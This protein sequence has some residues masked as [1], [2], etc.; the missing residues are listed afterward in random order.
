MKDSSPRHA[1]DL[2]DRFLL[3]GGFRLSR[4]SFACG[5]NSRNRP[6]PPVQIK[7]RPTL[8]RFGRAAASG[9]NIIPGAII[10]SVVFLSL[11][12][13][14]IAEKYKYIQSRIRNEN[15]PPQ[16]LY[17]LYIFFRNVRKENPDIRGNRFDDDV[18]MDRNVTLRL[19]YR[20]CYV[21]GAG[22]VKRVHVSRGR[23]RC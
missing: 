12:S 5:R 23:F 9:Q 19:P 13:P 18:L 8:F 16:S 11:R 4:L 20:S 6:C 1:A 17:G 10:L 15:E 7:H 21:M 2:P 22:I 14:R 3:P